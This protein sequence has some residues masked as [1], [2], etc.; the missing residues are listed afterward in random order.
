MKIGLIGCVKSKKD[1]W[2]KARDIYVSTLFKL[3]FQYASRTCD[4]VY[5]LSARY[6]VLEPDTRIRAYDST[7]RDMSVHERKIWSARVADRLKQHIQ[8]G[9]E[10]HFFCGKRYWE[11]L[12]GLLT[13]YTCFAPLEGL[14]L[15][16]QL[17]WY[18]MKL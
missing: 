3:G 15:G 16:Q 8:R 6:G 13:A 1:G 14:G 10:I 5:I 17:H 18:K 12:P 7:L 4:K 9:A 11:F 2:H